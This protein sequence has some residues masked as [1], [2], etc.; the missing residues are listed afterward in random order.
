[1]TDYAAGCPD[2]RTVECNTIDT[3]L[4]W[5]LSEMVSMSAFVATFMT[6]CEDCDDLTVIGHPLTTCE[7][8][9]QCYCDANGDMHELRYCSLD[10][11]ED[12]EYFDYSDQYDPSEFY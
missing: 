7:H 4:S 6:R 5:A 11:V 12:E 9:L 2:C 3:S 1:V 8:C 10:E